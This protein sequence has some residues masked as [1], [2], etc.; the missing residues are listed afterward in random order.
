MGILCFLK[1]KSK[2]WRIRNLDVSY[3]T[4]EK[5]KK[6]RCGK[7]ASAVLSVKDIKGV[8]GRMTPAKNDDLACC[9]LHPPICGMLSPEL[10][11]EIHAKSN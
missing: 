11:F 1:V 5:M 2:V 6:N 9:M 7:K 3:K 8:E 10:I 4:V